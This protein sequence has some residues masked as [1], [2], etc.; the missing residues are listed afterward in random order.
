MHWYTL[1]CSGTF[2]LTERKVRLK[3]NEQR[4]VVVRN[5]FEEAGRDQITI[6][7]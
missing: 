5:D 7:L 6:D 3:F 4:G 1:L 2:S